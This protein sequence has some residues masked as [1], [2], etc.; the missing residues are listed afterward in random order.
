MELRLG[1][2]GQS[3][4]VK[5]D[6]FFGD[7]FWKSA[8]KSNL[9]IYKKW[10]HSV[11]PYFLLFTFYFIDFMNFLTF[12]LFFTKKIKFFLYGSKK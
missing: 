4:V 5:V 2:G 10:T 11:R 7:F 6:G 12:T 3:F 1:G 9:Q 8:E